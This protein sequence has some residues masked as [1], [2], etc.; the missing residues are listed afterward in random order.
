MATPEELQKTH[1]QHV[2]LK[3]ADAKEILEGIYKETRIK[4]LGDEGVIKRHRPHDNANWV[5]WKEDV[6]RLAGWVA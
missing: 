1:K 3:L 5:Y 2:W 6:Y 4:E